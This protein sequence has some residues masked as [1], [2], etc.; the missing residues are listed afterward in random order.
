MPHMEYQTDNGSVLTSIEFQ[1][2]IDMN[3][4][5][6]LTTAPYRPASNGMAELGVQTLKTGLKQMTC[7]MTCGN[8]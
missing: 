4:I 5:R 8:I 3:G 7:G 2:F 6:H 1:H